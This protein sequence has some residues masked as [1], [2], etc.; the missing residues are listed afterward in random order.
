MKKHQSRPYKHFLQVFNAYAKKQYIFRHFEKRK[1]GSP[2]MH[3]YL[4]SGFEQL[5]ARF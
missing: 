5:R 2:L 3:R 4:P 1:N